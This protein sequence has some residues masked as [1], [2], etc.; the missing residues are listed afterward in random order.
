MTEEPRA[1]KKVE[2]RKNVNPRVS[3]KHVL[4][5]ASQSWQS[6]L[7][8][9]N[10]IKQCHSFAFR[11]AT[12]R[13]PW[14]RTPCYSIWSEWKSSVNLRSGRG[15]TRVTASSAQLSPEEGLPSFLG[16]NLH[17]IKQALPFSAP[18]GR[19]RK[20]ETDQ[21]GACNWSQVQAIIS[22]N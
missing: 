16:P 22:D 20:R 18:W 10:E 3:E 17:K 2:E 11:N 7:N 19:A 12:S 8:W 21:V 15:G 14:G 13:V 1:R 9:L 4:P 5:H 6:A